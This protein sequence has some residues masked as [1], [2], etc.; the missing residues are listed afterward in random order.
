MDSGGPPTST[1]PPQ[2]LRQPSTNQG[3]TSD[4]SGAWGRAYQIAC[5]GAGRVGNR[6]WPDAVVAALCRWSAWAHATWWPTCNRPFLPP[7]HPLP[8]I[9]RQPSRPLQRQRSRGGAA[10]HRETMK[11]SFPVHAAPRASLLSAERISLADQS[12]EGWG[13][14]GC[15]LIDVNLASACCG[16]AYRP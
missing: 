5:S 3:Y 9:G 6:G 14:W 13:V 16:G 4:Q 1:P 10:R 2:L 8:D 11:A 12:G 15:A 7:C